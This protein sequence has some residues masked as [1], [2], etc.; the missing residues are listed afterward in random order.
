[1]EELDLKEL[2]D[3]FFSKMGQIILII[4]IAAGF[5][6]IYTVG[7]TTPKYSSSTTLVLTS[8]Q[9]E[10]T[11]ITNTITTTDVTL[12]SKLVSTYSEL[13]K[14]NNVLRKVVSNLDFDISEEELRKNITVKAVEDT[15]LIE[16]SVTNENPTYAA[17]IANEIANVFSEMV[18]EIY[19]IN[20]IHIVDEAEISDTPS[21]I[22]HGKDVA[23]F[24]VAGLVVAIMYVLIANVLDTTVKS[25]EDIE[26][27]LG[28][29]VLVSIPTIENFDDEK[30]GKRI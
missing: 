21:N 17:K 29:P 10:G 3:L 12:N 23:I 7:F 8:E 30:G 6:V 9:S 19:N 13:V 2:L 22:Q 14:S 27:G 24:A 15:E 25:P 4:I 16:I 26:K 5:G 1:M 11:D 20:N 18:S 28:L